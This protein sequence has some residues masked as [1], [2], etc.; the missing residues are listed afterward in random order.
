M[1][2]LSISS[3]AFKQ[4]GHIPQKYTCD[5]DNV[6]P[7]IDIGGV[8]DE[9]IALVLI[10]DDPDIPGFVK[11]KFGI[12]KFDHWV[13]FNIPPT[14]K[15]IPEG[16]NPPGVL[17]KN[18]RGDLGYTGPCPPDRGHRYFLK[19]YA[20]DNKLDLKAGASREQVEKA[21][22]GFILAKREMIALYRRPGQE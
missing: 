14:T 4:N 1:S 9:A 3:T 12:Q 6:S 13:V 2:N 10:M 8:P 18:G 22:E 5:G 17:G 21:M 16:K 11:E 20:L 15:H 7:P 19:L